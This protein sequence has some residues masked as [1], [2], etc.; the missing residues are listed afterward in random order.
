MVRLRVTTHVT[1][2]TVDRLP[3]PKPARQSRPFR[4]IVDCARRLAAE[5]AD[6]SAYARLPAA[7][8]TLYEL[9]V[10]MFAHVLRTFPLIDRSVRDASL[11]A[12]TRTI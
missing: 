6:M 9:D 11:A 10:E 2:A 12:L 7:A 3:L 8:A 1:V 5:P 4:T